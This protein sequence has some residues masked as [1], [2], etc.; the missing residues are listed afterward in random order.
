MIQLEV[1]HARKS[2]PTRYNERNKDER[3]EGAKQ[4]PKESY[5][6]SQVG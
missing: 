6:Q 1:G 4:S 2:K 3:E 5:R